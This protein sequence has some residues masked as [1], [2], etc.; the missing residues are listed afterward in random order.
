MNESA[1]RRS[2]RK[3]GDPVE[4]EGAAF[5]VTLSLSIGDGTEDELIERYVRYVRD[6]ARFGTT[7]PWAQARAAIAEMAPPFLE[8]TIL[9]FAKQSETAALAVK[10]LAQ[11]ATPQ[12]RAD[13][14]ALYDKSADLRLRG[15]I[16][17]ALA[18]IATSEELAFFSNIVAD[19]SDTLDD[20]IR[21][22]A[23]LGIGRLGGEDAVTV[24][25]SVPFSPNPLL[26]GTL[27]TALGNTR[28]SGAIPILIGM[29][30]D[31]LGGSD[32]CGA[33]ATLTH[34][35]WCDDAGGTVTEI[36]ARWR[37][38]WSSHESGLAIYGMDQCVDL[39]ALPSIAER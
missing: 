33:L 22:A 3:V 20:R 18:R 1:I 27:A 4:V 19:C 21:V 39:W 32:V 5:D 14:V 24:L 28:S 8:K 26:R 15:S 10:G 6:A 16:V 35:R 2:E 9:G 38:W 30:D 17:E 36:Q 13:L 34:Q 25:A 37:K 31:E 23:L 11:I 29:Y 7:A 12:S